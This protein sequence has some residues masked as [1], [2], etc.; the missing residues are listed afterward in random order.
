MRTVAEA[1]AERQAA[2][3]WI[4]NEMMLVAQRSRH[5]IHPFRLHRPQTVADAV[6][7]HAGSKGVVAYMGGGIDLMAALKTGRRLDDVIHLGALPNRT[8]INE[9][10]DDIVVGAG[11]THDAL[12]RSAVLRRA[13]PRLAESWAKLANNRIRIKGTIAGNL[14]AGNV[15]YDLP[16]VAIAADAQI[17]FMTPDLSLGS[18]AAS[19]CAELGPADLITGIRLPGSGCLAL[20]VQ[21]EWKPIVAFALS[22]RREADGVVARLAVGTGFAS[23][24]FSRV[25]LERSIFDSSSRETAADLADVLCAPLPSPLT[26]WR[27]GSDYRRSLLKVLVRREIEQIRLAGPN[28][29]D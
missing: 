8:G 1:V 16:M 14:M 3:P 26:D 10:G 9:C 17:E 12:A 29:A 20:V 28:N 13:Y 2:L 22:F 27:A 6:T 7:L 18:V 23:A 4:G 15:S 5:R 19:R 21:L 11:V 25:D 24:G